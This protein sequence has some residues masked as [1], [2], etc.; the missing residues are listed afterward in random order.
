MIR[1]FEIKDIDEVNILLR[2]LNYQ[3]EKKSFDNDFL[4][5]LVFEED[6]KIRG[7]LIYQ[8]L[9]DRFTIDYLVVDKEYRKSKISTKLLKEI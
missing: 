8:D 6:R 4:K 1:E 9:I 7:V 2:E 3:L 5:I